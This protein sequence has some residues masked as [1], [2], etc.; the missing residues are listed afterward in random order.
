M[1]ARAVIRSNTV[2]LKDNQTHEGVN[3]HVAS[4]KI[5]LLTS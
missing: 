2:Y 1:R 5:Y 3:S 4:V